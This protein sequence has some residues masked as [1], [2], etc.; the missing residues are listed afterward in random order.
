MKREI[1]TNENMTQ[2]ARPHDSAMKP[3]PLPITGQKIKKIS[4][5][6]NFSG[7]RAQ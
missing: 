1:V 2:G 6:D 7:D 4:P 3:G 5:G